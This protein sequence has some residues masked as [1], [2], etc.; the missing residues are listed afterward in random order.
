LNLFEKNGLQDIQA[1]AYEISFDE[2][3]L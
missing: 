1:R 3:F 2:K